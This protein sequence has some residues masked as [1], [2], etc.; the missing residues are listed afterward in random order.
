[1]RC[2]VKDAAESRYY[3]C[4]CGP[5]SVGGGAQSEGGKEGTGLK[6]VKEGGGRELIANIRADIGGEGKKWAFSCRHHVMCTQ[7]LESAVQGWSRDL[8]SLFLLRDALVGVV[9]SDD[10]TL[11]Q[12]R[13]QLL[14]RQWEEVCHQVQ[15]ECSCLLN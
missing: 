13:L 6:R 5:R 9:G 1:M 14:Q 11:L 2:K 7:E 8:T 3:S 12:E 4:A 10:I 15:F